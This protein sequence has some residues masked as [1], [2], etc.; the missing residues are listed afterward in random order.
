MP[1]ID[2][3]YSLVAER[4]ADGGLHNELITLLGAVERERSLVKAA[5]TLNL[6]YRTLW[7]RIQYWENELGQMLVERNQGR[8]ARPSEL[9]RKLLWAERTV[10]AENALLIA[11]LRNDFERIFA[12]ACDPKAVLL[13]VSGCFDPWLSALPAELSA[14]GIPTALD[15]KFCTSLEGLQQLQAGGC[16]IAAFNLPRNCTPDSA[17]ARAFRP[18]LDPSRLEGIFFAGR[19]QGLAVA[20]GNPLG[21]RSLLDC[22]RKKARYINRSATSGTGVLCV[23]LLTQAGLTCEDI[24]GSARREVS[25]RAVATAIA[26]GRADAGLCEES[27]ARAL[28]LDFTPLVLES[29]YLVWNKERF[30]PPTERRS[31]EALLQ[32]LQ[33]AAWRETG[34]SRAGYDTSRCGEPIDAAREWPWLATASSS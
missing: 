26:S 8:A 19:T 15:L 18:H 34:A 7:G 33:T 20:A 2:F 22:A 24:A 6:S 12:L 28:G 30:S 9:G 27:A 23:E 29:Y 16:D 5:R 4:S 32:L 10:Q 25:H 1:G 21:L 14:Q 17:F 11:Q 3:S 31:L 13:T